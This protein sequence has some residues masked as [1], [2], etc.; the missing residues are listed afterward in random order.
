MD[1]VLELIK[2]STDLVTEGCW[3]SVVRSCPNQAYGLTYS[4]GMS[5]LRI[6]VFVFTNFTCKM[7]NVMF[8]IREIR[9]M[10]SP[11]PLCHASKQ[12]ALLPTR[13]DIKG[14]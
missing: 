6:V 11:L 4:A 9:F 8:Q 5:L 13:Y 14:F 3:S 12:V 1:W 7:T 2:A 10:T